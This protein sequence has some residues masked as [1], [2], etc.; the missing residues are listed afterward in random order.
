MDKMRIAFFGTP[1]FAVPTLDALIN[2]G[3][4][5]CAV[6]TQPDRP[7]GRG[8]RVSQSP[9]HVHAAEAGLAVLQPEKVRSPDFINSMKALDPDVAVV[10]AYGQIIPRSLL[11]IPRH[12]FLNVHASLLPAYRGAAPINWALING[13][14]ETGVTIM[15]LDEGM[16]T[17]D[18]L[19]KESVPVS[20][21]DTALTL[22]D[23][24]AELGARLMAQALDMLR[25]GAL[26]PVPQNDAE[27][28]YAPLLKKQDG[29]IDWT[30]DAAQIHNRIRG[31]T[32]W[33]GCFT[34]LRGKRV[35]IHNAEPLQNVSP[36]PPG[37]ILK[38]GPD[39][40]LVTAGSGCLAIYELQLEG[41]K[42]MAAAEFV[43][44]NRVVPG[45]SFS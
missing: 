12:G 33:P 28:S 34:F 32:P 5:I 43:R 44:G 8:Q 40:V 23:R 9:V 19:L 2:R 22:H 10:V 14:P 37:Q 4:N 35:K 15:Q 1:A 18:M 31:M 42:Q 45:E 36:E 39:S 3:E 29:R 20:P 17:G 21:K 30:A 27:A 38:A 16:D 13:E 7:V 6:V 41:K 11:D 25:E 24:L 26:T